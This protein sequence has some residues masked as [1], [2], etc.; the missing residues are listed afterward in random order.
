VPVLNVQVELA[1]VKSVPVN[2]LTTT[3]LRLDP[4]ETN[5]FDIVVNL[6]I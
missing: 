2:V 4:A 5:L 1:A 3:G 6:G